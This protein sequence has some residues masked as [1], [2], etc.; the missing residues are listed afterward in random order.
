MPREARTGFVLSMVDGPPERGSAGLSD[1]GKEELMAAVM[2]R[3]TGA[4]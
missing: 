2:A 3:M 1:D 4:G